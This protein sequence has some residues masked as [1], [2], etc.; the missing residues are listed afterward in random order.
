MNFCTE[1]SK[2]RLL[3]LQQHITC[4]ANVTGKIYLSIGLITLLAGILR[5]LMRG[6]SVHVVKLKVE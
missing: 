4:C 6:L 3:Q 1:K 5:Y 2:I